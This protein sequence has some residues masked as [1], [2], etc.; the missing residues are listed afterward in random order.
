MHEKEWPEHVHAA[1]GEIARDSAIAYP[2]ADALSVAMHASCVANMAIHACNLLAQ[3]LRTDSVS[4]SIDAEAFDEIGLMA[5]RLQ[6][7]EASLGQRMESVEQR[8]FRYVGRYQA[9]NDYKRGDVVT[10]KGSLWS[11]VLDAKIGERPNTHC[12]KWTLML[13]GQ[14]VGNE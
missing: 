14:E 3:V 13:N 9:A 5:E 4:K 11:C 6:S 8:G 7:L 12:H 10:H 2:K 1:A